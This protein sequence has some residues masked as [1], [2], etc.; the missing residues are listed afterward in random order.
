MEPTELE[1]MRAM[2]CAGYSYP[3][4]WEKYEKCVLFIQKIVA[5]E[6]IIPNLR[7]QAEHILRLIGEWNEKED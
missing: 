4:P 2:Q 3:E 7:L 5:D 6:R 1:K